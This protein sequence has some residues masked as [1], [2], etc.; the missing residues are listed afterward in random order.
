MVEID[1]IPCGGK[2]C[3]CKNKCATDVSPDPLGNANTDM[4]FL[5]WQ[6]NC[7]ISHTFTRVIWI[8]VY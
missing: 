2:K 7:N 4:P 6:K 8:R 5:H 3:A 1:T